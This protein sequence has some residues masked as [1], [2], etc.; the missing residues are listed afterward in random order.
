VF[1]TR[2][3]DYKVSTLD[4]NG[5][6]FISEIIDGHKGG[7]SRHLHYEQDEWFC[8][9]EVGDERYRLGPGDSVLAPRMVPHVWAH[10]GKGTGKLIAAVQPAGKLEA[11]FDKLAMVKGAPSREEMQKLFRAHG[12][13]LAG[14]AL[15]ID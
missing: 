3:I 7:P 11:F 1:G 6:V 10:V 9:I 14:P 5:G 12:M 2:R 4:T 15:A 8:V 13:D